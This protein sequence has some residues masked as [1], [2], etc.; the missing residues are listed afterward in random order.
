MTYFYTYSSV[1][2][3]SSV[4]V[5][6]RLF[7]FSKSARNL[8][9]KL[10]NEIIS[11]IVKAP[12]NLFHDITPK[13]RL[14]NR[15]SK[16]LF[17]V[18]LMS[19]IFMFY[20]M[21]FLF[22]FL[23]S[24]ISCSYFEPLSLIFLPVLILIGFKV[25]Y[26]YMPSNRELFRLEGVSRSPMLSM[27]SEIIPGTTAIRAFDKEEELKNEYCERLNNNFLPFIYVNGVKG[28]F[29]LILDLISWSFMLFLFVYAFYF[30][31]HI[32]SGVIGIL[33][34]NSILL[35]N[36]LFYYLNAYSQVDNIMI[37]LERCLELTK[38]PQEADY[39]KEKDN[40]IDW[41]KL[42]EIEFVD[43]SVSYRPT[44]ELVLKEL[45]FKILPGEKIGIVGR[46]G[47][48]KST[49]CLCLFRILEATAGKILIDG[50]DIATLGLLKLRSNLTIIPQD[51]ILMKNTLRYNIDP[52][53]E[54]TNAHIK[55]VFKMINFEDFLLR[56]QGLSML[57]EEN[58]NN[59]S[60]GERQIICIVRAILRV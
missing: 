7:L 3:G 22:N 31:D 45:N 26:F 53:Q 47:S 21:S 56:N 50:V 37:S 40:E 5:L 51:P 39:H 54:Y 9:I 19:I 8:H 32:S 57:I 25:L 28:W 55:E 41:P 4:F 14:L 6:I 60:V 27:L 58:G 29:G 2:L 23:G 12:I 48:G 10:H 20:V 33:I 36:S 59:L 52:K 11:S 18:D 30:K 24:I 17:D 38:I 46:T 13:G 1:L 44:T 49:T 43:Y 34:T 35:Q 16:E 42:G 15:L